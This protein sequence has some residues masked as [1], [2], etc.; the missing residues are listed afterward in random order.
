MQSKSIERALS[1]VLYWRHRFFRLFNFNS[2]SLSLHRFVLS[3]GFIFYYCSLLPHRFIRLVFSAVCAFERRLEK[4]RKVCT[5]HGH[6]AHNCN[7]A[8]DRERE[9]EME[10]GVGWVHRAMP[11][12]CI[13]LYFQFCVDASYCALMNSEEYNIRAVVC[14]LLFVSM[15]SCK[16]AGSLWQN[17]SEIKKTQW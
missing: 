2:H 15:V 5:S 17:E 3:F 4:L 8:T 13:L 16:F 6:L 1:P 11:N 7:H 12:P 14:S 9:S 10:R